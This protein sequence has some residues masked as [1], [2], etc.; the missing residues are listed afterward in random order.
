VSLIKYPKST[1][2]FTIRSGECGQV[3]FF[4]NLAFHKT[5]TMT[6]LIYVPKSTSRV[7]YIFGVVFRDLLG[8]KFSITEQKEEF[9]VFQGP[10]ISYAGEPLGD[11]LFIQ[12][13]G[14]LFESGVDEKSVEFITFNGMAAFFGVPDSR[15]LLPFDFFAAAFFLLSRYEEYLPFKQDEYGRFPV[16]ES[17]AAK[18]GFLRIPVINHWV[19]FF[20]KELQK[21]FPDLIFA[22]RKFRFVPTIDID[23]AFAYRHR[24]IIRTLGGLGHTIIRRRWKQLGLRI[25]VL[26]GLRKDPYDTYEYIHDV[27]KERGCRL[28]YFVLYS[29]SRRHDN[30]VSLKNKGFLQLLRSLDHRGI[31]GIHPSLGSNKKFTRLE[32]EIAG[33]SDALGHK[34][35]H[36]RQHFLKVSFPKTYQN[37][38]NIGIKKD[39]SLG[40]AGEPGFKA[41]IADPFPFYNL[42]NETETALMIH[43]ITLMDVTLRDYYRL[44]AI[45]A[46]ELSKTLIDD[47]KAVNGE[48]VSLW[49]NES[50]SESGRWKGWRIVYEEILDYALEKPVDK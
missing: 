38:I 30:N 24:S 40:Y 7:E 28:H 15:S 26:F 1:T 43:P 35:S 47:V 50:F 6:L 49:H 10:K 18:G 8:V 14:L 4:C 13:N 29:Q 31:V 23:H 22:E 45:T 2:F 48:F 33:L 5:N 46:T 16:L 19:D 21:K 44:D 37:L 20:G 34:I 41:S 27:H 12:S 9:R 39:Y 11:E 42:I 17:T 32:S 36:S 3:Y 25:Q